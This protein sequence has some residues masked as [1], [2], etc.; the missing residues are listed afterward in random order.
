MSLHHICDCKIA[1]SNT[2]WE[3]TIETIQNNYYTALIDVSFHTCGLFSD[4]PYLFC[5]RGVYAPIFKIMSRLNLLG[6]SSTSRFYLLTGS[7]YHGPEKWISKNQVVKGTNIHVFTMISVN[8]TKMADKNLPLYE[9][10]V[11]TNCALIVRWALTA[12]STQAVNNS[13]GKPVWRFS[14][15]VPQTL[16]ITWLTRCRLQILFLK[17]IIFSAHALP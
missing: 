4:H 13:F 2:T 5:Y 6:N 7:R 10:F 15:Q 9:R 14:R 11:Y 12:L 16:T 3:T 8:E 1:R 17:D